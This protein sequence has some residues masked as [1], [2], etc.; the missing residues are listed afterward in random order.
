MTLTQ[1]IETVPHWQS[2]SAS[3][4]HAFLSTPRHMYV[5]RDDW[6]WKG[7]A[8]VAIPGTEE[9][10]GRDGCRKLQDVLNASGDQWLVS[11]IS[12]GMPLIDPEIQ[13]ILR[14][15]DASGMV[16]NARHVADAVLR[17]INTYEL[18]HLPGDEYATALEL[19]RMKLEACKNSI[20]ESWLDRLQTAREQLALWDGDPAT[21]PKL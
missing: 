5:D 21:E 11:Q 9:R 2:L 10:F 4:V 1:A 13:T 18:M 19:E 16:P 14:Q 20:E 12:N 15:L 6:T 7:I 8:T 3:Q 17:L